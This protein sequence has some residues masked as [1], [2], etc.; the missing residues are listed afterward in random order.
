M[1][2]WD[3]LSVRSHLSVHSSKSG[4]QG[5]ERGLDPGSFATTVCG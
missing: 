2:I 4:L 1:L 5:W 3:G